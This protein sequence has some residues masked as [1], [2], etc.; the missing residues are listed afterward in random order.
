MIE[1]YGLTFSKIGEK[2]LT[3][4][5]FGG[6]RFHNLSWSLT[7]FC[8]NFGSAACRARHLSANDSSPK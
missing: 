1:G 7:T 3:F 4:A 2:K 5:S 6:L 8:V